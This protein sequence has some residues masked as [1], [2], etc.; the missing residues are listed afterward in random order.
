MPVAL[1]T[2][3]LLR[4]S[5]FVLPKGKCLDLVPIFDSLHE[6]VLSN[7]VSF[8]ENF[9]GQR[10]ILKQNGFTI[11]CFS[12]GKIMVYGLAS[13]KDVKVFLETVWKDFFCKKI[14]KV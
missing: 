7:C 14:V 6:S 11:A 3:G 10:I 1:K 5:C 9:K 8:D 2:V 12:S 4:R 13:K